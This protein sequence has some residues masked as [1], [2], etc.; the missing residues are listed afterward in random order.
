MDNRDGISAKYKDT[1]DTLFFDTWEEIIIA[2]RFVEFYNLEGISVT[3]EEII[4]HPTI[5]LQC[6]LVESRIGAL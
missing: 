4:E 3:M 6:L 5:N 2:A 1:N